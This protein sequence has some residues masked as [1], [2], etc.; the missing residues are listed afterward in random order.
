MQLPE[1]VL[2]YS[3]SD[4]RSL[5]NNKKHYVNRSLQSRNQSEDRNWKDRERFR[6]GRRQCGF[7]SRRSKQEQ[8]AA[9]Q[10]QLQREEEARA[11]AAAME[12]ARQQMEVQS[13]KQA[14]QA[15]QLRLRIEAQKQQTEQ[16]QLRI[17]QEQQQRIQKQREAEKCCT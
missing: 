12:Q 7:G 2:N 15:E 17:E 13:R 11:H 4:N 5:Q 3:S 16:E 9:K 8:L 10:E 6:Q 1:L 14:D